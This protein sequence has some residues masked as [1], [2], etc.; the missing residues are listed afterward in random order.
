MSKL[1]EDGN[2]T[3]VVVQV[4][5]PQPDELLRHRLCGPIVGKVPLAEKIGTHILGR[6]IAPNKINASLRSKC[7]SGLPRHTA[8]VEAHRYAAKNTIG[9]LKSLRPVY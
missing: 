3:S 2:V 8:F 1:V 6:I 5:L 4:T 9:R 7:T